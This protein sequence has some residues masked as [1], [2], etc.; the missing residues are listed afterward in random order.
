[1]N[2]FIPF[3][4]TQIMAQQGPPSISRDLIKVKTF[5]DEMTPKESTFELSKIIEHS[6]FI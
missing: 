2:W 6:S 4:F 1:M 5:A 3:K